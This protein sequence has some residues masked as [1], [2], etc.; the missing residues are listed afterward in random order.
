MCL[1]ERPVIQ[2]TPGWVL[3]TENSARVRTLIYLRADKG[4]APSPVRVVAQ[5][6][7]RNAGVTLDQFVIAERDRLVGPS[8]DIQ[9]STA[10]PVHEANGR[11]LATLELAPRPGREGSVQTV[12]FA[13][14][15]DYFVTLTYTADTR[16][17]HGAH[18]EAFAQLVRGY[19]PEVQAVKTKR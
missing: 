2:D 7:P 8:L 14:D 3:D 18:L 1:W 11:P 15:G 5:A 4:G 9:V 17:S 6:F 13:Q 10:K 12:A 19:R 16:R